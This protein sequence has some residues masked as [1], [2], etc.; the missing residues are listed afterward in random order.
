MD[1]LFI[2]GQIPNMGN[3]LFSKDKLVR[4]FY[5]YE[6][7]DNIL[8]EIVKAKLHFFRSVFKNY[9]LRH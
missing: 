2:R 5:E 6:N 8:A 7:K 3:D 1:R 4:V 9:H